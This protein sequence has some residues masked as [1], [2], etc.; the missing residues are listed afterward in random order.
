M[1]HCSRMIFFSLL[2]IASL[3]ADLSPVHAQDQKKTRLRVE[4]EPHV[5][6]TGGSSGTYADSA[7]A[8][9]RNVGSVEAEDVRVEL[10]LPGGG[11]I[12]LSGPSSLSP[13]DRATYT[14]NSY[15]RVVGMGKVVPRLSCANCYR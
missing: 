1:F 5:V 15:E 10:E 13:N 14:W 9:V 2:S 6:W 8:V 12:V 11:V 3:F 7:Q 4:G